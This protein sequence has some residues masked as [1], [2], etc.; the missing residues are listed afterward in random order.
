M[1]AIVA[2]KHKG[3]IYLAGDRCGSNG[4]SKSLSVNPKIFKKGDF[5][6]GYT[7]S[8]Y[9]GQIL[10]H[11]WTPPVRSEGLDDNV[12]LYK[13]VIPS[14]KNTLVDNHYGKYFDEELKEPNLGSFVIVYKGRIFVHHSNGA[15][16][17]V[18]YAGVGCGGESVLSS[19]LSMLDLI[20]ITHGF[21]ADIE[22]LFNRA[23]SRCAEFYCG[24]S[25]NFD[26]MEIA[27][28]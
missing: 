26:L 18:E 15:V 7:S 25:P 14:L 16:I 24:V 11:I 5:Y 1:T 20:K 27:I 12:Y 8:F 23:F 10:E 28:G 9:M 3:I 6:L 13:H 22:T 19:M 4:Y 17:E 21:E 2:L